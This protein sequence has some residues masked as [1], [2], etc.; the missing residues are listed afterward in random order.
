[1]K[2]IDLPN[3]LQALPNILVIWTFAFYASMASAQGTESDIGAVER[4][5]NSA[6]AS[7][8]QSTYDELLADDFSWTFVSGRMINRQQMI[9]TIGPVEIKER[10]KIILEYE[11]TAVVTGIASLVARGRPLTERF[12]RV[13]VKSKDAAWQLAYFQATELE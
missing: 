7:G 2:K 13:W 10:D 12:V 3:L 8:D 9:E 4:K 6:I 1:M 11:N 5:W